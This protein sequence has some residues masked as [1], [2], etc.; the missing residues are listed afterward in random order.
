MFKDTF[1]FTATVQTYFLS[2]VLS[3]LPSGYLLEN[4]EKNL[5]QE[6]YEKALEYIFQF[7]FETMMK[8]CTLDI[9]KE[10]ITMVTEDKNGEFGEKLNK[11]LILNPEINLALENGFNFALKVVHK[12]NR[13]S[14]PT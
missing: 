7:S 11:I 4:L 2:K 9:Q 1:N 13:L 8:A 3:S 10:I 5:D 14:L 6:N 12:E